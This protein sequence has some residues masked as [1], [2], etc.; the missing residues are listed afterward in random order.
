MATPS[1]AQKRELL[2]AAQGGD[3][4]AYRRLV[5]RLD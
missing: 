4:E 1:T 2:Q 5:E 3:H